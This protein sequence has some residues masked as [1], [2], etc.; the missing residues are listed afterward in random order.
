MIEKSGILLRQFYIFNL[1]FLITWRKKIKNKYLFNILFIFIVALPL[2]GQDEKNQSV[3][4]ELLGNGELYSINHELNLYNDY[5]SRVGVSYYGGIAGE[6]LLF[7]VMINHFKKMLLFH[8]KL[9]LVFFL[10]ISLIHRLHQN[11]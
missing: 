7:P 8:R 6:L 1:W 10:G 3:C 11:S 5:N 9:V 2:F 4:L